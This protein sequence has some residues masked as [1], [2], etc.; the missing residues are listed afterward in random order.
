MKQHPPGNSRTFQPY[1]LGLFKGKA[2]LM[3]SDDWGRETKQSLNRA[4]DGHMPKEQYF[5]FKD[6]E[7]MC[8]SAV[9][10][11]TSCLLH[12]I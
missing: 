12:L 3:A 1:N 11:A 6:E 5:S 7:E 9:L 4:R 8:Q 2:S 10:L